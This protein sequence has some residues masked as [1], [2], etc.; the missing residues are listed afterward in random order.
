M[1]RKLCTSAAVMALLLSGCGGSADPATLR[2]TDL[3]PVSGIEADGTLAWKGIPFAQAPVGELRWKPPVDPQR[4]TTARDTK[5][6]ANA[7]AQ[8]GRLY[9]PG[10]NNAYDATIGTT[11]GQTVGSEDCLYLNVWSPAAE[12]ATPRP[13]IVWIHGGSNIVGYTADPMY[14][15]AQLAKTA[16]AIVVSV[17]YRLGVFGFLNAAALKTADATENS[18]NFAILDLVKALQFVQRNV[19]SF[20]GDPRNVTVMGESAG[21]TNTYAL[22]TSPQVVNVQPALFHRAIALSGGISAAS[23]LA[24]GTLPSLTPVAASAAQ[25]DALLAQSLIADGTA[26]DA[27]AAQVYIA[28][29]TPAQ[30]AAYLRGKSADSVLGIVRTRLAAFGAS[31]SGPIPDGTVVASNPVNA[32]KAGNYLKVPVLGG[33]TRDEGKL[34]PSFLAL[35]P[36]L[37]G[38]SGRLI[39]DATVFNLAFNYNPE[40]APATTVEQWIPAQYLPVDAPGTGFTAR[41]NVLSQISFFANNDDVMNALKS[42]QPNVWYYR[43]DWD[44]EPAPFNSIFG[45]AHGFDMPFVFG[46]FGPSLFSRFMVTK[47]NEPGRLALSD[48]MMRSVGAFARNGNPNNAALG[49]TWEPWPRKLLFDADAAAKRITLQ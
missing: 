49:T 20:G 43:F 12:A 30:L 8:T 7:C 45:S 14:D 41:T 38:V 31:G 36:A 16:D 15:G 48:A 23:N 24:A 1:I 35:S 47:A 19:A 10:R 34:F 18:G 29:R 33:N 5:A 32:I 26:V 39:D 2:S 28:S 13:V 4:W 37:G 9:S 3:G 42:Q 25:G 6:F 27:D 17:N 21:A 22:L 46:T 40:A 11:L 44:E